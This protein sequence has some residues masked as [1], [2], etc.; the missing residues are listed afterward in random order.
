MDKKKGYV[1]IA[2]LLVVILLV[3]LVGCTNSKNANDNAQTPASASGTSTESAAPNP[4][5]LKFT[6]HTFIGA[7]LQENNEMAQWL[8]ENKNI[9][10]DY[11][12]E[13]V[14]DKITEKL[15]LMLASGEVPDVMEVDNYASAI[16]VVNKMGEAGLVISVD[17]WLKKYPDLIKYSDPK[18]ND[19]VFR[20]KKDGKFYMIPTNYAGHEAVKK[21][22]VGPIIREDWLKQVGMEAPKTPDELIEVLRAFKEK[23]PDLNG[24]KIIPAS[25]D[26]FKQFIADAW[27]K[28]YYDLSEDNKS[29]VFQFNDPRIEEYM[30]FMNKLYREGLLDPEMFA[31]QPEQYMEKLAS[32]RVGYTVRIYW[33]MD[34]V[35]A[36]LKAANPETR[37]VPSPVIRVPGNPMPIYT[38]GTPRAFTGLVISKKFAENGDNLARLMEYLNWCATDDAIRMLKYGPEGKYYEKNSEGLY[39]L[40]E[41]FVAE[42]DKENSDFI[43]KTGLN[44][45]NLLRSFTI[46]TDEV[47]PRTEEA[48]LGTIWDEAKIESDPLAFQLTSPG[49]IETEKWGQMWAEFDMWQSKA[50]TAKSEDEVRKKTQEMLKAFES[51]GAR[52]IVNERL[53]SIETFLADN[54]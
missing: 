8:K 25:F 4:E 30:V 1:S 51:S 46:P 44:Q 27:T 7:P 19:A 42:R 52:D 31:Q 15:N 6:F 40:K 32:G 23:I 22:D 45:Y 13:K 16:D 43:P 17:E 14:G 37:F 26:G 35:N 38:S 9:E 41:E 34:Q 11:E 29:L 2:I 24:K 5:P 39:A 20:S 54:Q 28:S 36:S 53:K 49:P 33:D 50:I 3:S 18:Y 12:F 21:S 48:Q 47:N 10:F